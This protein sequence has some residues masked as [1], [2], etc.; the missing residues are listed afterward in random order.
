MEFVLPTIDAI[1]SEEARVLR[2]VIENLK[3]NKGLGIISQLKSILA[4]DGHQPAAYEAAARIV[5]MILGDLPRENYLNEQKNFVL[6][7]LQV[8]KYSMIYVEKQGNPNYPISV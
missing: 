6:E 5:A 1:L 7:L 2:E 8:K 3:E 4:V